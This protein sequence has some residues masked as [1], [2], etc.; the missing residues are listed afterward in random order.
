[1]QPNLKVKK[2]KHKAI[3]QIDLLRTSKSGIGKLLEQ[4]FIDLGHTHNSLEGVD[5]P[6]LAGGIELKTKDVNS[7]SAWTIGKMSHA[8][9][10]STPYAESF[11]KEKM[12]RQWHFVYDMAGNVWDDRLY[13]FTDQAIQERCEAA[14]EEGRWEIIKGIKGNGNN[15]QTYDI[16]IWQRDSTGSW[17]WRI[18]VPG[19]KNLKEMSKV[20]K[21]K[22]DLFAF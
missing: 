21:V 2:Y 1:M 3:S 8:R 17:S 13:D 20:S 9:V 5:L 18:T 16:G 19:M 4:S 14:Y 22:N 15:T 12:Q 7:T 10:L 6:L 11:I